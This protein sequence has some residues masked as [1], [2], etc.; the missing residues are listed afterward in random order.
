MTLDEHN[1]SVHEIEARLEQEAFEQ[2]A[3]ENGLPPNG[4]FGSAYQI[5]R[6]WFSLGWEAGQ[7]DME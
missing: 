1:K 6:Y 2:L 7:R 4:G 3:K 5:A